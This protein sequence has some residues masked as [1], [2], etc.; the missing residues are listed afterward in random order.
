MRCLYYTDLSPTRGH[1]RHLQR[2]AEVDDL[3]QQQQQQQQVPAARPFRSL[4]VCGIQH[5]LYSQKSAAGFRRTDGSACRCNQILQISAPEID[6]RSISHENHQLND[7]DDD[8]DDDADGGDDDDDDDDDDADDDDDQ[9]ARTYV[10]KPQLDSNH[11]LISARKPKSTLPA[12]E[13]HLYWNPTSFDD[14]DDDDDQG[15]RTYCQSAKTL[16][17]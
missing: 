11:P 3:Q 9:G 1:S 17:D 6:D 8:D 15:A 12:L 10:I 14:D 5:K 2:A 13:I 16:R 7:V 4:S